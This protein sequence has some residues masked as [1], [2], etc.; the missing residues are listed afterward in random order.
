MV[1]FFIFQAAASSINS[2]HRSKMSATEKVDRGKDI[3]QKAFLPE[4]IFQGREKRTI[5]LFHNDIFLPN[6]QLIFL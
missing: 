6:R 4:E 1:K 2:R 3:A 5:E